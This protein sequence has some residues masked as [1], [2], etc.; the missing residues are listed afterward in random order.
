MG[1]GGKGARG[2]VEWARGNRIWGIVLND[3]GTERI[4]AFIAVE[5]SDAAR[6]EV[7]RVA[8]AVRGAG[9]RGARAARDEGLHMTLRFL[10]DIERGDV[11]S[12]A[13]AMRTAA[14][15]VAPFELALGEVGAFPSLGRARTLFVGV[16]GDVEALA[17]LRDGIE[18]G[19]S[20][21]G[22][23]RDRRRFSPHIT[24]GR[25]RERVSRPDRRAVVD[26]ARSVDY[27]RTAFRVGEVRLFQSTLTPD[28]AVY[29][30]LAT[31]ELG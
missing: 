16:D 11:P 9:V 5:L 1:R 26:A 29:E 31:A 15:R 27:A 7:A 18:S 24:V 12:V 13:A 28:G 10:G 21:A 23:R 6:A 20:K 22:F 3:M 17:A 2:V 25:V 14:R 19:L 30:G 8:S 4:R